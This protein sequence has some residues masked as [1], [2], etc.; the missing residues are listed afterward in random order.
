MEI[1]ETIDKIQEHLEFINMKLDEK[2]K[3]KEYISPIY[4]KK[5]SQLHILIETSLMN[6]I[7]KEAK[8]KEMGIAEFV[9]NK[10]RGSSQLDRLEWK[11]D[12]LFSKI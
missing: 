11:I 4:E 6:K 7:K 9:R 5:N 2:V 10:L 3:S 8:E 1:E 12:K